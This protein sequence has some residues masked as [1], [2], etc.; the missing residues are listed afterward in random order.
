M[1]YMR[2]YL[3]KYTTENREKLKLQQAIYHQ[4]NRER[5]R[6]KN[7]AWVKSNPEK[8]AASGKRYR[9]KYRAKIA[10]AQQRS[11]ERKPLHYIEKGRIRNANL[12][13]EQLRQKRKTTSLWHKAHP[14]YGLERNSRRRA[15]NLAAG[16]N[17]A[18]IQK[19]VASVRAQASFICYY[20]REPLP[21]AEAH[22][23]HI[24]PLSRGG[25]HS[26]SNLCVSCVTCNISKH[27][28]LPHEWKRHAQ[29]FL[30]L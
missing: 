7:R 29:I 11:R 22:F 10:I 9:A 20:C 21:I 16:I 4:S 27:A 24:I 14:E 8:M 15:L 13:P 30:S 26:A 28:K 19:W 3:R 23:D 18:G 17:L 12:T 2:E 25:L 1:E 5:C 6:A